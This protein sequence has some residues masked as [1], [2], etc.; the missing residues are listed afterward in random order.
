MKSRACSE[1]AVSTG[2]QSAGHSSRTCHM[3]EGGGWHW[4]VFIKGWFGRSL[5]T[6][7]IGLVLDQHFMVSGAE[8]RTPKLFYKCEQC[9]G[10]S[11]L[12]AHIHVPSMQW[13][14]LRSHRW[15]YLLANPGK[16]GGG[17]LHGVTVPP[18]RSS[19]TPIPI[20]L[21]I[22]PAHGADP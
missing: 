5:R 22:G 17:S 11:P 15:S 21:M 14:H 20:G 6:V 4:S 7:S 16:G 8:G 1:T 2:L 13:S 3:Y 9:T 12:P 19:T 10:Y 18:T